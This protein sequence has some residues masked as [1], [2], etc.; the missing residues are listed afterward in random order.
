MLPGQLI[1]AQMLQDY[2]SLST[3]STTTPTPIFPV[4]T[5][6]PSSSPDRSCTAR[7]IGHS[8]RLFAELG[9]PAARNI[10]YAHRRSAA[11]ESALR[12]CCAPNPVGFVEGFCVIWCEIPDLFL[13]QMLT[14][15]GEFITWPFTSCLEHAYLSSPRAGN[16]TGNGG[17]EGGGGEEGNGEEAADAAFGPIA[18][19]R[20]EVP[21]TSGAMA[22]AGR[23]MRGPSPVR[24]L[25]MLA[26][27]LFVAAVPYVFALI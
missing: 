6:T 7:T 11:A 19:H 4:N 18:V 23:R 3:S 25:R 12:A 21:V 13:A 8:G 5:T 10:A 24:T 1:A 9:L 15:D 14:S 20:A 2:S 16:R 17:E 26:L 27:G 22:V